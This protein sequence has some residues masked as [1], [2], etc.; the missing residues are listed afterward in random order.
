[1][2]NKFKFYLPAEIVKSIDKS[3][4]QEVMKFKGLASTANRDSQGEYLDP[5]GFDLTSFRQINWNHKGK[6]DP[7]TIIGEPTKAEITPAN[8]LYIEG[9]LYP[10][11]PMARATFG[12]MKAL[13]KS[14][15]GN[16]LS[17]S[18]EGKVTKRGSNDPKNPLYNKILKSK[19]TAVA[20][21]PVP[22]NGDTWVDLLSKGV[23]DHSEQIEEYDEDT[24]K[25]IEAAGSVT[26]K[27]SVETSKDNKAKKAIMRK[28]DIYEQIYNKYPSIDIE[29]AK[30]VYSLIEKIATMEN[31]EKTVSAETLTKAFDIL[32]LASG[33]VD[34]EKAEKEKNKASEKESK[35]AKEKE[36]EADEDDNEMT[37]KAYG[38]AKEMKK[39]GMDKEAV[40]AKLIK[41]GYGESVVSKAITKAEESKDDD[42]DEEKKE[43][44][45]SFESL[46]DLIKSQN[47]TFNSKFTAIGEILKAQTEEN[48]TLKK[49]L[50]E[51][52]LANTKLQEDVEKALSAPM[53]RKSISTKS[54]SERFE[55][56]EDGSAIFNI[57]NKADIKAL[58]SKIENLSGINK[59]DGNYNA[60]L[61][62]IAQDLELTKSITPEGLK[63]LAGY[64][65]KVVVG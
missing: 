22:V 48:E 10:E 32:G 50:D 63:T 17:L 29:K 41:K 42:K 4:G 20:I 39:S 43:M 36:M 28:S 53:G 12:L 34:L 65:I 47:D 37:E 16:K 55:K 31:S 21:C 15:S 58:K 23:S 14:P 51:T 11:L 61:M 56:S 5:S 13:E 30:S 49:S 54:F 3:N 8:E 6:D 44:K 57:N 9:M 45:K 60:G 35:S 24:E 1:M 19:I 26:S 2:D 59:G 33:S 64:D 40:K 46:Q 27:E 25:A 62:R 52:I 7:A 18:V 38:H